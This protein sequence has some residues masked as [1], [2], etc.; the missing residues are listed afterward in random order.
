[1]SDA[2]K[3]G[4]SGRG[5]NDT[6]GERLRQAREEARSGAESAREQAAGAAQEVKHEAAAAVSDLK[7]EAAS[8]AE[9]A[10]ER[11]MSLAEEQRQAGADRAQ[12]LAGAVHRA[13]DQLQDASPAIGRYVHEAA[14]S[15]DGLARALRERGP[16]ELIG[17]LETIARRQPAAFFGAS[18][19]AGF[20]LARFARSS[21]SHAHRHRDEPGH[22]PPPAGG[23]AAPGPGTMGAPGWVPGPARPGDDA[24]PATRPATTAAATLGGA[25]AARPSAATPART[26]PGGEIA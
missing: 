8:V 2:T 17:Q 4:T 18:V 25:A 13:V 15:L 11:A 24:I 6:T 7:A 3:P 19:L 5:P 20:A 9:A 1:M 14:S 22:V 23:P 10:K 12:D 16:G 21:A 26:D